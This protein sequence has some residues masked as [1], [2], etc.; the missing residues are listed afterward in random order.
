MP[1]DAPKERHDKPP[2]NSQK[3]KKKRGW[4][5]NPRRFLVLY[6]L[7][8]IM[9]MSF[10][11][12]L[13][14]PA[15]K[16]NPNSGTADLFSAEEIEFSSTDGTKLVGWFFNADGL[17]PDGNS[18][19]CLLYMHG[20]GENVSQSG[21]YL[22][23]FCKRYQ[24]SVFAVDY[25]GYGKSEGSPYEKGVLQDCESA[26]S[27]LEKNRNVDP[28]ELIL[29]GRSLGGGPAV[30]LA[31]KINPKAMIL[32][33]TF[34]SLVSVAQRKFFF[35]P[36]FLVMR[37]RYPSISK[38]KSVTCPL[39]QLHGTSDVVVPI[40][41]GKKLF[42]ACQS[43]QKKFVELEGLGHNDAGSPMFHDSLGPFLDGVLK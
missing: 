14:Y 13:V 35:F 31:A 10:E 12:Y 41:S 18:R 27:W 6:I 2:S 5:V 8:M 26:V 19:A 15:P 30:H 7:A 21:G 32:E 16:Y 1:N 33:S 22:E 42:E 37:N 3:T 24:V 39:L 17:K 38:I 4:L 28:S 9:L 34:S 43:D 36:V 11:T 25:R 23:D 29:W 40:S 20:N